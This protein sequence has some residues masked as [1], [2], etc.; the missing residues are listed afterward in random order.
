MFPHRETNNIVRWGTINLV[1]EFP[2]ILMT[3]DD[4]SRDKRVEYHIIFLTEQ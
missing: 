1:Y 2:I 4:R 3:R